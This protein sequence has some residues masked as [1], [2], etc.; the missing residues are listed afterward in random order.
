MQTATVVAKKAC[1]CLELDRQ[2][3]NLYVLDTMGPL[4]RIEMWLSQVPLLSNLE[5]AQRLQLAGDLQRKEVADGVEIMHL[6]DRGDSMF[7]VEQ[8]EVSVTIEDAHGLR[9]VARLGRG[10]YFGEQAL[11]NDAPRT[12]S[13]SAT[14][15]GCVVL[16]LLRFG[17]EKSV[18]S[19]IQTLLGEVPLL[20]SLD[21]SKRS[22]LSKG[23]KLMAFAPGVPI[24]AEG[25]VGDAF[26][27]VEN[28]E[29]IVHIA[30]I[31][32]VARKVRGDFFGTCSSRSSDSKQSCGGIFLRMHVG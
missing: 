23:M 26:Y 30:A 5:P 15:S 1:R 28:G 22:Y 17:F 9:E 29:C 6:G 7:I 12:A 16:E 21:P 14:G 18:T 8:G 20:A 27:I 32:E 2:S 4:G 3:F 13:V 11:L 24:I 31:G 10:Q 19:H 25:A